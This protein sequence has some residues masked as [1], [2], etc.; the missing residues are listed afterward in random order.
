MRR[1]STEPDASIQ[2]RGKYANYTFIVYLH[3][4][5]DLAD[6]KNDVHNSRN[7]I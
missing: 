5:G 1:E 6:L 2:E 3:Y 7:Y 4:F